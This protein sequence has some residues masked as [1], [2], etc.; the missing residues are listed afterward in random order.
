MPRLVNANP[1]LVRSWASFFATYGAYTGTTPRQLTTVALHNGC[2]RR[3]ALAEIASAPP[4]LVYGVGLSERLRGGGCEMRYVPGAVL[5][6]LN[7]T[8]L[9]GILL[10]R[11][12]GGRLWA[13]RRSAHW[14]RPRRLAHAAAFPL[15]PFVMTRRIAASEGW[16]QRGRRCAAGHA[17]GSGRDGCDPGRR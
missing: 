12:L 14:S 6:H 8:S 7:I 10:D 11:S 4:D 5:D 1:N 13:S 2:F 16:R 3:D 15:A 17:R 9:R